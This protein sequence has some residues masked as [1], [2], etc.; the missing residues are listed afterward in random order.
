[1]DDS[2]TMGALLIGG[3]MRKLDDLAGS[4]MDGDYLEN[5]VFNAVCGLTDD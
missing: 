5:D 3:Y 2:L 1:M 4:I